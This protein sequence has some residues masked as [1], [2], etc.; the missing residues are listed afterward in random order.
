MSYDPEAFGAR[1]DI[2]PMREM[3]G[4]VPPEVHEG[5]KFIIVGDA[6]GRD[7][8]REKRPFVGKSGDML[9]RALTSSGSRRKDSTWTNT[10]LCRPPENKMSRLHDRIRR[11][12]RAIA[13]RNRQAK[14]EGLVKFESP[15]LTP[16]ECC[17]PRLEAELEP[18]DNIFVVGGMAAKA[19]VSKTTSVMQIRGAPL[20]LLRD[21]RMK[22][23]FPTVHPSFVMRAM[24]WSHVFRNDVVRALQWFSGQSGFTRPNVLLSPSPDE[25]AAFLRTP[26]V[27]HWSYDIETD[28]IECL[29]CNVR[30]IA[31]GTG[32]NVAVIGVRSKEHG[33]VE[34]AFYSK[35][36]MARMEDLL[37][38]F[39]LDPS[40]VKV[41]HNGIYYDT[42][43]IERWLGVKPEPAIDTLVLHRSVESEMPHNLGFIGKLYAN[44]PDW[45]TDREGNKRATSSETDKELHVYC[46]M[47]VAITDRCVAP[48]WSRVQLRQQEAVVAQDHKLMHICAGMHRVGMHVDQA[49]RAKWERKLISA[50]AHHRA[51]LRTISGLD[52][53]NPNSVRSVRSLLFEQWRLDPD[54]DDKLKF[55]ASGDHS[56]GNDVLLACL[57]IRDLTDVQK[58]GLRHLRYYRK[59]Q[60]LLGTYVAKLR[61]WD[62]SAELGWDDEENYEERELRLRYAETKRGIVDPL[63]GRMHPGYN[64]CRTVSGRLSSSKPINAQNFPS[65]LREMVTARKGNVLVGADADQLELRIAASLWQSLQYLGAFEQEIDPHSM[66]T[67]KAI[68]GDTFMDADGWP[69][70]ANNFRWSGDAKKF[71]NLGK[72]VQYAGQYK[73]SIETVCRVIRQTETE[74]DDGTTSLPYVNI[75]LRRVRRMYEKWLEGARFQWGWEQEIQRFRNDRFLVDPVMGRRRDFLDGED[76]N[77]LVNF[78]VQAAAAGL[79][80]IAT[81]GI[82]GDIPF[83]KWGPGTGLINQ[84]HDSLIVECPESEAQWVSEVL[85]H[86]LNTPHPGIPGV[87]FTSTADISNNWRDVG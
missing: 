42:P 16:A 23:I 38:E 62:Q 15:I 28:G 77:E 85:E 61:P 74:N 17:A 11:D 26:G 79:I 63:T 33:D 37:R 22:R 66:V 71:R 24:R 40:K 3:E 8:V 86:H 51:K 69:C 76:P 60:K 54:I 82:V 41:A 10:V 35:A 34:E 25:F 13:A 21:G 27:Q 14:K 19:V 87:K 6:P 75:S 39:F 36:D 72:R 84:C 2:C 58:A 49:V 4:P 56:T 52:D 7:E 31:I 29:S 5:A 50:I 80:N 18:F 32:E 12:N 48:L 64:A 78:R 68:F 45:K 43:V 65:K 57:C 55:T 9:T 44:A 70:E 46:A 73:G 20:E 83:E 53:L 30:C 1:C 47:D 67:G 59:A 81:I